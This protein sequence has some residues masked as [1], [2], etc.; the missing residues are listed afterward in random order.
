MSPAVARHVVRAF[1]AAPPRRSSSPALEPLTARETEI[2]RALEDGLSYQRIAERL[3]ISLNTVR[4]HV[5]NVYAKLHVKSQAELLLRKRRD[6]PT[7]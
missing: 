3:Y 4:T 6:A 2:L 1:Q 7:A 5:K